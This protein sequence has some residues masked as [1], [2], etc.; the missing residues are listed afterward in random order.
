MRISSGVQK[1]RI[2]DIT[3]VLEGIGLIEKCVKNKIR[4]KGALKV[5]EGSQEEKELAELERELQGFQE[6]ESN[7]DRWIGSLQEQLKAMSSDPVYAQYAYVTYDDI[8]NLNFEEEEETN[9]T[10]LAIRA[11][12]GS[13][14]EIPDPELVQ[15]NNEALAKDFQEQFPDE[16]LRVKKRH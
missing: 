5:S 3:N 12:P 6:E 7:L 14:L 15:K 4:W 11:P 10:L 8:K 1:R 13:F 16:E 9:D 2:Y